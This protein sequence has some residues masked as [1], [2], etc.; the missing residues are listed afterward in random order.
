MSK[1]KKNC[2]EESGI[3]DVPETERPEQTPETREPVVGDT[4][5]EPP[6]DTVDDLKQQ[7]DAQSDRYLRLMAEFDNFKK[8][9]SRDYE[10]LV[11]SANE[12]LLGDLIEVRENLERA[13]KAGEPDQ[14]GQNFFDGVKLI[15]TKFDEQLQK[16]G[17]LPFGAAGETFDP[18]LHDALM[19]TPNDEIPEDHI[20]EV[21]EKG[22]H[23]RKRVMRH[24]KVIVS[25][26]PGCEQT[27]KA[28]DKT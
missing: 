21:F 14:N 8:R 4:A 16:H 15:F 23:L 26:G 12:R 28:S 27:V 6:V 10:R 24:A 3:K 9:V 11:E 1:E 7:L 22:Y 13:I 19:K 25:S 5:I 17:L 18:Q 20:V 2:E